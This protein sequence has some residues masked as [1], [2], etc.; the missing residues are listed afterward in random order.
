MLKLTV[1]GETPD[2]L[3]AQLLAT[4]AAL[5]GKA[6]PA[7]SPKGKPADAEPPEEEDE[8]GG[9][10]YE[11]VSALVVRISKEKG[12]EDV[13]NFLKQFKNPAN[14]KPATKGAE[15]APKDYA[16]AVEKAT[17]LLEEEDIS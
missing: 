7:P 17:A 4:A 15:I 12:R 3:K 8:S 10:E 2:D 5:G 14:G 13:I 16:K 11:T 9:I 6:P 1:E